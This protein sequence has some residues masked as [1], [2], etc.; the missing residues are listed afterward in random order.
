MQG[1]YTRENII[2]IIHER[3]YLIIIH[4]LKKLVKEA[5]DG[6]NKFLGQL[7]NRTLK[8]KFIVITVN[9]DDIAENHIHNKKTLEITELTGLD[10]ARLLIHCAKE[11]KYLKDFKSEYELSR[12]KIFEILPKKP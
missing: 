8:S 12:H 1:E 4:K 6:F 10:A 7:V 5:K 3:K 9:K 11:S 2:S